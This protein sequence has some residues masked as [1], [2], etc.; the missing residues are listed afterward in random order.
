[1][2]DSILSTIDALRARYDPARERSV[3]KRLPALD[4]TLRVKRHQSF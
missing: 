4:E 3:A 2:S 1:M